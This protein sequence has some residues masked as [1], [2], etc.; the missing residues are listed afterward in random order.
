MLFNTSEYFIFLST[1]VFLVYLCRW[2]KFSEKYLLLIGSLYFYAQWNIYYLFL[3]YI[4]I[5]VDFYLGRQ[6]FKRNR[7]LY[8]VLS[9]FFN[10]SILAWFKY[11]QFILDT[12]THINRFFGGTTTLPKL[13]ILLP[14]GISFYTFQSLSYTI[15]LYR[16]KLVPRQSYWDY[17][18]FISFFPQLVAGPIVKARLFFRQLDKKRQFSLRLFRKGVY[19]LVL[20]LSK[21]IVFADNLALIA[22]PVFNSPS[23]LSSSET[24]LGVL[25]FTFQIYFDFSGYTDMAIGSALI[26]GFHFPKN[27]NYPY[28]AT[29]IRE[30]WRRW[31]IS[32]SSWLRDYLYISLGGSRGSSLLIFRNLMLTMLL[33]GLWHGASWNFV[34]WGGLHGLYMVIERV[35]SQYFHFSVFIWVIVRWFFTFC[36]ISLT[37]IFFRAATLND[38]LTIFDNL[39]C[40]DFI[41]SYILSWQGVLMAFLLGINYFNF[42]TK[43]HRIAAISDVMYVLLLVVYLILMLVFSAEVSEKFIYFQF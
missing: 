17:A 8:L 23:G 16:E 40:G 34:I 3:I 24:L 32:L 20:G 10:L 21:K 19:L 14:V 30:F 5:T 29:S 43:L 26:L 15:D 7:M 41:W 9:I 12:L 28:V 2:F 11:S 4:T 42:R 1:L 27:F 38:S 22:D 37:W 25:A 18:L 6:I 36:L 33:G 13:N 39:F 31:H 35:A